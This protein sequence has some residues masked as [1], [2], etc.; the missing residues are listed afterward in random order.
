[1]QHPIDTSKKGGSS[2]QISD[3]EEQLEQISSQI[4]KIG[5]FSS[6]KFK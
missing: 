1:L 3:I 5:K 4:N 6:N 2:G